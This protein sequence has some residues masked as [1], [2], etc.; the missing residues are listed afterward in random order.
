MT[1][2]PRKA[3]TFFWRITRTHQLPLAL[4]ERDLLEAFVTEAYWPCE[5]MSLLDHGGTHC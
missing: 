2:G 1:T 5:P 3:V 4:P